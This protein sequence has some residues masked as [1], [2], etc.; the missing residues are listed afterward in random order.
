MPNSL[1]LQ[2]R[3]QALAQNTIETGQTSEL[4]VTFANAGFSAIPANSIRVTIST[5]ESFYT[6]D[7]VTEPTGSASAFFDW[8]YLGADVWAWCPIK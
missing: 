8:N 6:T 3:V 7:G 1:N 5:S 2:L 4:K